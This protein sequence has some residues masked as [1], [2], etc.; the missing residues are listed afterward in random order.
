MNLFK[1]IFSVTPNAFGC[2]AVACLVALNGISYYFTKLITGSGHHFD[3]TTAVDQMI[4]FVPVW[5]LAYIFI[6]YFQ[7]GVGYYLI[8]CQDK[9]TMI[10]IV[11]A[12]IMAKIP[13]LIIFLLIPT[14]MARP[15]VTGTDVFSFLVRFIYL[16]DTPDNLFPSYH[17]LESYML[18]R[19]LPM[20]K[21]APEWYKKMTPAATL[22]VILSTVFVK[23]HVIVDILGGIAVS[24][25]GI[26]TM[27]ILY[28]ALSDN[29]ERALKA[30]VTN[31]INKDRHRHGSSSYDTDC[32]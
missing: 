32:S 1:K 13:S 12:E 27:T 16:S 31:L 3:F 9:K 4:P 30:H 25:F 19:I 5:I 22:L 24:E 21:N 11:G 17:V 26:L 6:A 10:F 14:T 28:K 23:Q 2:L 29:T 8:A 18:L 7:W 15:D 20:M